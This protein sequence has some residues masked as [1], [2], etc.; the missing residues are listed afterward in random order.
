MPYRG[1]YVI[2]SP[3]YRSLGCRPAEQFIPDLMEYLGEVYYAG[4]LSA[5]EYHGAA[6]HRPQVFQVVVAKS[7][8]SIKCG[9]VKVDFIVKNNADQ[10]PVQ[11]RNTPAGIVKFSSPECTAFDLVGYF[12]QCGWLDNVATVLADL[13]EKL[14][15]QKLVSMAE[16]VPVAWAQRLGYLLECVDAEE[17]AQPLAEYIENRNPVRA[18][19]LSSAEIKGS[20]Y[21]RRWRMF[22]NTEVEV[23]F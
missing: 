4:L 8:R 22:V 14:D 3:E 21:N 19:L 20:K 17:V 6:H 23:E 12:K 2:V 10:M 16:L 11:G 5:A 15:G 9:K 13:A 7:R 1:F 18:P